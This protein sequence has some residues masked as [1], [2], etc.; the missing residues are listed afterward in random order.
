MKFL[1]TPAVHSFSILNT[2]RNFLL[3]K[4]LAQNH[5]VCLLKALGSVHTVTP[6]PALPFLLH[7]CFGVWLGP[8]ASKPSTPGPHP[9]LLS[10]FK[11][12]SAMSSGVHMC[13]VV[14]SIKKHTGSL[15]CIPAFS[16]SVCLAAPFPSVLLRD[17]SFPPR[18]FIQHPRPSIISNIWLPL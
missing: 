6:I 5:R 13:D 1:S 8:H 14:G 9:S 16:Q 18:L 3:T 15:Q 10:A 2:I 17:Y 7:C 12:N 4:D 11:N